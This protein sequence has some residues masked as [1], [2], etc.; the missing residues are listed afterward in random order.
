MGW[1]ASDSSLA[2]VK[3]HSLPPALIG[4]GVAECCGAGPSLPGTASVP[5]SPLKEMQA[6]FLLPGL[7]GPGGWIPLPPPLG[8]LALVPESSCNCCAHS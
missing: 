4:G 5:A 7:R 8:V 6:A 2:S 3:S 1:A